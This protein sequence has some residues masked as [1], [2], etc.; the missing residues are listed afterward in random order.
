M[1]ICS[2][3]TQFKFYIPLTV[4]L[5]LVC[6]LDK[7]T[8]NPQ[9]LTFPIF[10]IYLSAVWFPYIILRSLT[11]LSGSSRLPLYLING[12]KIGIFKL[13]MAMRHAMKRNWLY[14]G[15]VKMS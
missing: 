9:F 3:Q 5:W 2:S 12:L 7:L 8:V 6:S 4:V 15:G 10:R 13:N 1:A 11:I 14:F